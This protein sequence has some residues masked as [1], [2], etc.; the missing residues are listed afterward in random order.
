MEVQ[1]K[2]SGQVQSTLWSVVAWSVGGTPQRQVQYTCA[3]RLAAV[4]FDASP[5]W[6]TRQ[7]RERHWSDCVSM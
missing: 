3:A 6:Y 5:N 2:P 1:V 4:G 7:I